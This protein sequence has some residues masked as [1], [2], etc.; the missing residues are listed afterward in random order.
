MSC[1]QIL[2]GC[3]LGPDPPGLCI[4]VLASIET[5][6]QRVSTIIKG[7]LADISDRSLVPESPDRCALK[8]RFEN[9]WYGHS[10]NEGGI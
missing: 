1:L 6:P 8:Q 5:N 3:N 2:I 7:H 10:V 4:K 9:S